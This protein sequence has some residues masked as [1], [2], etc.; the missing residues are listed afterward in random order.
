MDTFRVV[1]AARDF[2]TISNCIFRDKRASLK[3]R[4]LLCTALSLPP[5][6]EFSIRGLA[7]IC[8]DGRDAV[9]AGLRELEELGYLRREPTQKHNQDGTFGGTEYIFFEAPQEAGEDAAQPCTDLPCTDLPCT[10]FPC[11]VN[12]PQLN[13]KQ[14]NINYTT[15]LYPPAGGTAEA[16]DGESEPEQAEAETVPVPAEQPE[17]KTRGRK[18]N[19]PF[20]PDSLPYRAAAYLDRRIGERLPER[21]GADQKTLQSWADSFDKCHRIDG[22]SWELIG[23]LLKFCQD[24]G[25]WQKNILSGRTFR[26]KLE[27]LYA[28]AESRGA[29]DSPSHGGGRGGWNDR[30]GGYIP[31]VSETW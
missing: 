7:T 2:T 5:N 16:D 1:R 15:P 8:R 23:R 31:E 14:V 4:G 11:T 21:R 27:K 12:P 29:R 10:G 26:N 25:F 18:P 17:K 24:N 30:G 19:P 9:A 22:Y 28:E 6:W 13:T 3:A 20:A